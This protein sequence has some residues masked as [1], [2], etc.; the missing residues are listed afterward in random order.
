MADENKEVVVPDSSETED[1]GEDTEEEKK[2][3]EK[4][5]EKVTS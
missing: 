2:D 5:K 3:A 1:L 4:N